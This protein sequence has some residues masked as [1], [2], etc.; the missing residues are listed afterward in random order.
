MTGRLQQ[1]SDD[2]FGTRYHTE[3]ASLQLPRKVPLRIEPKSYFANER[4]FLAWLHMAVTM[5]GLATALA[6]YQF[7]TPNAEGTSQSSISERTSQV[8]SLTLLPTAIVMVAY[9][10]FAFY[11]RSKNLRT[12][13]MGFYFDSLGPT[14]LAV[15]DLQLQ[16]PA[17]PCAEVYVAT[18]SAESRLLLHQARWTGSSASRESGSMNLG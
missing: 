2:L 14:I 4:T 5:G 6:G 3:G 16:Q 11:F 1:W 12:K 17:R 18:V 9:A 15:L 10:S 13:Q 7:T 8:I